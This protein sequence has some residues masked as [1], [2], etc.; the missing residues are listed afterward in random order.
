MGPP[1]AGLA[2]ADKSVG[3]PLQQSPG[4]SANTCLDYI[5]SLLD[6]GLDHVLGQRTCSV[7]AATVLLPE[8]VG[9]PSCPGLRVILTKCLLT[10]A[11]SAGRPSPSSAW[12]TPC[13]TP[14]P[15]EALPA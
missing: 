9:G 6:T 11:L 1:G 12:L 10:S 3:S 13:L 14:V 5:P 4:E 8:H 7:L 2:G 15:Q